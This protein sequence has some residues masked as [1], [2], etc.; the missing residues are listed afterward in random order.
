LVGSVVQQHDENDQRN[1]NSDEPK[2]NGHVVSP[3]S[4]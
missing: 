2:Q 4:F 1:G 3:F